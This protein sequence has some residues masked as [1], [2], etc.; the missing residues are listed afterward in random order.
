MPAN[1]P[2]FDGEW[3]RL[4]GRVEYVRGV[5]YKAAVDLHEELDRGSYILLRANNIQDGRLS[6]DDVQYVDKSKVK[7]KQ[8]LRKGDI[9]ICASSGSKSLVGKAALVENDMPI[10]FGAFCCALRPKTGESEYLGHYFQS[11]QYRKAIERACSG[12]NINNLKAASFE[13]LIVPLYSKTDMLSVVGVLDALVA[14]KREAESQLELLDTLVKSRFVEMF[15]DPAE[16]TMNWDLIGLASLGSC[17]NGMNF[18]SK[19]SGIELPCLGVGD[20]KDR[21]FINGVSE[22]GRVHLDAMP[23]EGYF[24]KDG[25]IVFVR[26]NGNKKLVGRCL[27][28]FPNGEKAVYSGFCIRLRVESDRVRIPYLI[29]ALRHP[30]MRRQLFG[31]GAN[32][33]NLNQKLMAKVKI[34]AP[35]LS[36]QD[37][38][39]TF[40][41][42][43]D[44]SRFTIQQKIEKLQT[45]YD[46]LAQEYFG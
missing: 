19:E 44:K 10:T 46:S 13:S 45:L 31:R 4:K 12:S 24:L 9:L 32:V 20:F 28:V 37:R 22:M 29:W 26:S 23:A 17:K 38:F 14:Q 35:P 21:S 42:E 41:A 43:V 16:N 39:L 6:F 40:V 3:V 15:G 5:T 18:K 36:E 7:P 2:P 27:A 11:R 34:P 30:S 8:L 1:K 25:D 33:Q